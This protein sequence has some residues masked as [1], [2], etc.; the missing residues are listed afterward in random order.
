MCLK[1]E[2]ERR[3]CGFAGPE[4]CRGRPRGSGFP[5]PACVIQPNM[6]A[7]LI[8]ARTQWPVCA[9]EERGGERGGGGGGG[10][11]VSVLRATAYAMCRSHEQKCTHTRTRAQSGSLEK[12]ESFIAIDI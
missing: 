4:R 2:I 9:G 5:E 12:L 8:C 1:S 3:A 6:H 10:G 7:N 11:A